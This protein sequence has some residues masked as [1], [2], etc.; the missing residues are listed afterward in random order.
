MVPSQSWSVTATSGMTNPH[1]HRQEWSC[2][3]LCWLL[4]W[5][6]AMASKRERPN[7]AITK[8]KAKASARM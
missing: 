5:T 3:P 2:T 1:L 6:S 4:Q 8:E 7:K